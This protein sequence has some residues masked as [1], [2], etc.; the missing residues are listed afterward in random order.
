M[1]NESFDTSY[2]YA[3]EMDK[4]DSLASFREEFYL[5]ADKIYLDGNSLGLMSKPAEKSL[6]EII[7]SWKKYGIDGWT[8][9]EN[10]WYFLSEK[11]GKLS[12][13]LI[14]ALPEEVIVT[15]STTTNIH[16]AIATL[17]KPEGKRNKILADELNFPSD[18]YAIQSQIKLKGY[19]PDENLIQ[20]KSRDGR[21]IEE[22]DIIAAMNDEIALILLPAVLYRSGQILDMERI[23]KEAHKR[24]IIIG[25]D[26]CHSIGAVQHSLSDWGVDF[27]IWCNYKYLNGGPGAVGGIYINKR[28]LGKSPGIAG[29]F[30][31]DKSKQFDMEHTLVPAENAG[32]Y[33]IGTPHLFSVA[34]LIGSLKMFEK[35]GLKELREKSLK[36]TRYMM[37]LISTELK[38]YEFT[39]GNPTDD[40]RRGGHVYLEHK[41]AARICKALKKNGVIPDF[42]APNGIRLAPV[43][44]YNS[45]EDVWKSIEILKGIMEK[46]EYKEFENER[47]VVA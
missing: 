15:G 14:G 34:P 36:L 6:L 2:E 20:V 47:D 17:Y 35:A 39:L 13:P 9:E 22:D 27:A 41:E 40:N 21:I 45:Y 24:N 23:T 28:H 19:D 44:L 37:D 30:S 18:I 12:A 46:E 33:Q 26:L 8:Q 16:Q 4:K 7:D 1:N 29:W 32:A 31:S 25:F 3:I 5:L 43:S 42:R 10:P 38:E 11:L